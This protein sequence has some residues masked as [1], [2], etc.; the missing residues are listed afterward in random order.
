MA[1]ERKDRVLIAFTVASMSR[2]G[3]EAQIDEAI[4]KVEEILRDLAPIGVD[5]DPAV[6]MISTTE[7]G[8]SMFGQGETESVALTYEDEMLAAAFL[9]RRVEERR[10]LRRARTTHLGPSR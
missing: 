3:A 7:I 4:Q 1:K 6:E 2:D 8:E 10:R 9:G 5:V